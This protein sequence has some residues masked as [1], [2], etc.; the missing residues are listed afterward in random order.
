M[1]TE[2]WS[3]PECNRRRSFCLLEFTYNKGEEPVKVK[4]RIKLLKH[5]PVQDLGGS[6]CHKI[7]YRRFTKTGEQKL[8]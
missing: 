2:I 8:V 4:R 5:F 7:I 6:D 1:F 3:N